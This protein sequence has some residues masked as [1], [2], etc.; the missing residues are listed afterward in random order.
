MERFYLFVR[1]LVAKVKNIF[2]SNFNFALEFQVIEFTFKL[3]GRFDIRTIIR[4]INYDSL[5]VQCLK[6]IIN[7]TCT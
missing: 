6:H 4:S 1:A 3:S 7:M 5:I 2:C